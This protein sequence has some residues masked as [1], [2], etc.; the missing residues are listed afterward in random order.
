M[1]FQILCTPTNCVPDQSLCHTNMNKGT[2]LFTMPR[3]AIFKF[4]RLILKTWIEYGSITIFNEKILS[5][6][7][8]F[9]AHVIRLIRCIVNEL[10]MSTCYTI[11]SNLVPLIS[12]SCVVAPGR[13]LIH[14]FNNPSATEG[15]LSWGY[16]SNKLEF[17]TLY[18]Y[19]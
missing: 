3:I 17:F 14:V 18:K 15:Y 19:I 5:I 6:C 9:L 11:N 12:S 1:T 16:L 7:F 4:S 2:T 8:L 13:A 10:S